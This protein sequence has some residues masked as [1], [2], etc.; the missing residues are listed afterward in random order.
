MRLHPLPVVMI[1]SLTERGAATTL[2]ALSLGA[3]D[4]VS[5]P[6][7]DVA[8]GLQGYAAE[9]IAKPP[10][11]CARPRRSSVPPPA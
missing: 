9:I 10:R 7:L 11:R 2:Q 6:K 1:S 8:R 4:F 5:K 3:V